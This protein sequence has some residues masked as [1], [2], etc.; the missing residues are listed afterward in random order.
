MINPHF[1]T[2]LEQFPE[3][4]EAQI[5]IL[6]EYIPHREFKKGSILQKP[7]E[8]PQECYQVVQGLLREYRWE[9]GKDRTLAFYD[10]QK[11]TVSSEYFVSESPAESYL[12]CLED[13]LLIVGTKDI[14][15]ANY[16]KFPILAEI[17]FKMMELD[18]N[19]QKKDF[20]N[21]VGAAPIER[22]RLFLKNRPGLIQRVPLH[23]IASYLG[24]R[25]E[26]LSR[27][28]KRI[29]KDA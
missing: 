24:I 12:E 23:Q 22:Y 29:L 20:S 28:R 13:S 26:S 15:T 25:A 5:E 8:V 1:R 4:D 11:G 17:S 27:I 3:L 18:R 2:F 7:G 16:E 21:F 6:A 10:E 14:D 19:A 9:D